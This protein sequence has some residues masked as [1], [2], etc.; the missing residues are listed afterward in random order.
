MEEGMY[1]KFGTENRLKAEIAMT[2]MRND[3]ERMD[4]LTTQLYALR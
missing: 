4:D 1:T 2:R 3:R